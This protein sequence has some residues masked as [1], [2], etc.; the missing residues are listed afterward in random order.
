MFNRRRFV[1][2]AVIGLAVGLGL[3]FA[4]TGLRGHSTGADEA[5][6]CGGVQDDGE[7]V[8]DEASADTATAESEVF[9]YAPS[10]PVAICCNGSNCICSGPGCRKWT[11]RARARRAKFFCKSF[12]GIG[13]TSAQCTRKTKNGNPDFDKKYWHTCKTGNFSCNG[14]GN[15]CADGNVWR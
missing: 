8:T 12:H 7:L 5:G 9:G 10:Y 3:Y 4:P 15:G 13:T 2:F 14:S 6:G 11:T 1:P